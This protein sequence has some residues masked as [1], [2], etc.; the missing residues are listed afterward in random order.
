MLIWPPA[1]LDQRSQDDL[2][3]DQELRI[4]FSGNILSKKEHERTIGCKGFY[5]ENISTGPKVKNDYQ[6]NAMS[7]FHDKLGYTKNL[8]Q[9][10][11]SIN[12]NID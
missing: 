12:E 5:K 8:K 3:K 2:Q 10:S 4:Q 11:V 7:S 9:L 1:F 6:V